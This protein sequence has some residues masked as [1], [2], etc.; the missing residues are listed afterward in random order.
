MDLKRR[1]LLGLGLGGTVLLTLGVVG[2][3]CG[4]AKTPSTPLKVLSDKQF[5]TLAAIAER[6]NPGGDGFPPASELGVAEAIDAVLATLHPGIASEIGQAL[7]LVENAVAGLLF[8]GR[9]KAFTEHPPDVQEIVW[10][11]WA[12][13]SL[14][15]RRTVYKA[16]TGLCTATYW[17]NQ[18]LWES[19]GYPG[20]PDVSS[21]P[22][23]I[24]EEW[25]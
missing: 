12:E 16:L 19:V 15:T 20:P 23:S 4:I 13:S 6:V 1:T 9:L 8:G 5:S 21:L 2:S 24:G 17:S 25:L 7:M 10:A 14:A 11:E 18:E 3:T 22:T